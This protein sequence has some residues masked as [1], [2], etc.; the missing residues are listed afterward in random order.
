MTSYSPVAVIVD[1]AA[2]KTAEANT[3]V[4]MIIAMAGVAGA[5]VCGR[6]FA[7]N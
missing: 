7:R 3:M 5:V 2:P 6:K 1:A 4:I